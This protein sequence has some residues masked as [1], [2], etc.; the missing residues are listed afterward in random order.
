MS[1]SSVIPASQPI[2]A[3]GTARKVRNDAPRVSIVIAAHNRLGMLE[4]AIDSAIQQQF[5]SF[6]VVIVDDGSEQNVRDRLAERATTCERLRVHHQPNRGVAAARQHGLL[7]ARGELICVLDSDDRIRPG[8]L[9]RIVSIFEDRPD[10]DLVY[11]DYDYVM[12][13]G[14]SRTMRLPD[15]ADTASMIRAT[16]I[17][18]T[19]PF[20]HSGTTFRR[21]VALELGGYDTGLSMKVDVDL[22]LKFLAAGRRLVLIHEPMVEFTV[23]R[24]SISRRRW[25]GVGVWSQLID[26]YGPVARGTSTTYKFARGTWEL[27]KGCY[28]WVRL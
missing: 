23:H 2:S 4:G 15:Y 5:E 21:R 19:V 24:A 20:K 7:V 6:E 16:L 1:V 14:S 17:R 26:R 3:S 28:E 10:A 9:R 8:A 13:G 27:A 12:P 25:E 18:P 11:A 22:F